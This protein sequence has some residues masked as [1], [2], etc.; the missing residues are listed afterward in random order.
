MHA[1][2][3]LFVFGVI[4]I[5]T[6]VISFVVGSLLVWLGASVAGIRNATFGKAAAT[7]LLASIVWWLSF[8]LLGWIWCIGPIIACVISLFL[9]LGIVMAIF[10]C[11]ARQA[12]AAWILYI[13][14]IAVV[15]AIAFPLVR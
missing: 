5:V 6:A 13:I 11:S 14:G 2:A 10:N 12:L 8:A 1:A 4:S 3:K 7:A 15:R 9:S